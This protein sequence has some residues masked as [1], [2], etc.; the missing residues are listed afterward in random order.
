M[1]SCAA[2]KGC[3]VTTFNLNIEGDV[4]TINLEPGD[5]LLVTTNRHITPVQ[6]EC[7]REQFEEQWPGIPV[8]IA[9]GM[10]VTKVTR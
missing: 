6:A 2:P 10:T 3:G 1:H 8:V 5:K 9:N 7:L 4:R